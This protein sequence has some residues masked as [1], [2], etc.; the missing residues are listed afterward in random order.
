MQ[1]FRILMSATGPED[2]TCRS[3]SESLQSWLEQIVANRS[4][5]PTAKDLLKHKFIRTARKASYLT[6]LID[7]HQQWKAE[8][9][10]QQKAEDAK[11]SHE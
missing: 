5:R 11:M 4:Q 6:E 1:G 2:G 3:D 9:G 10:G 8:G 7:K